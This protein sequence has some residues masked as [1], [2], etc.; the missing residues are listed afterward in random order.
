M[1]VLLLTASPL[2][3]L[4][5]DLRVEWLRCRARVARWLEE[6]ELLDEEMRRAVQFCEWKALWWENQGNRRQTVLSHL[7]EGLMAYATEQAMAER[8][9]AK[10]WASLWSDIRGRAAVVLKAIDGDHDDGLTSEM[11]TL[12]IL[13][14]DDTELDLDMD[15]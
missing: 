2:L 13:V 9:R 8:F 11:V 6:V 7:A 15:F 12:E 1:Y 10:L 5:T 3:I 14:D 4:I